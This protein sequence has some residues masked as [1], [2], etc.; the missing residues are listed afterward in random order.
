MTGNVMDGYDDKTAD[1]WT[2]T[3]ASE[4]V[5]ANIKASSLFTW[6]GK[7]SS[8][9]L[10]DAT[11]AA[12]Q[13]ILYAGAGLKR[14]AVDKRIANETKNGNYTYKGSNGSTNGFIDTQADVG[15][16]PAYSAT[17]D[18]LAKTLDTDGDGIPD[19]FEDKAGLDKTSA[20]DGAAKSLDKHGRYTNLEMYLHYLVKDIVTAQGSGAAYTQ[21]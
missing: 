2:G 15:G 13:V 17:D 5:I 1:N 6:S 3:T 16:W 21:L 11:G 14:D 7:E 10:H 19:W 18:E 4:T 9:S 20:S 8:L 12:A